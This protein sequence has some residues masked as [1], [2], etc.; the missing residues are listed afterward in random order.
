MRVSAKVNEKEFN[1]MKELNLHTAKKVSGG[2]NYGAE[3]VG[4]CV[5]GVAGAAVATG[6]MSLPLVGQTCLAGGTI[7]VL[8]S[9]M[10]DIYA[11]ATK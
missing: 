2:T 11:R 4:G 5:A 7:S 1:M 9:I 10:R 6:G 8:S 3:F